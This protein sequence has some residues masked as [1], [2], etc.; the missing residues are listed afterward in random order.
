MIDY[1]SKNGISDPEL[2]KGHMSLDVCKILSEA[3]LKHRSCK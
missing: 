1:A 2:L 3:K